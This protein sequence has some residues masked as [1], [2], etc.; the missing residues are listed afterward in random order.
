[1][2]SSQDVNHPN[3]LLKGGHVLD[4]A[5]GI[6]RAADVR[7]S[8]G[9]VVEVGSDLPVTATETVLDVA[10]NYVVPG[11]IDMHAHVFSTHRRSGLSLDPHVNTFSSGVTTVVDAG[12]AGWRDF[13]DFRSEVIDGARIR[14]LAYVNIVGSGMGGDWEHDVREM[15]PALAAAMAEEHRDVVVGIKTAHYWA[16]RPFDAEHPPWAAVDAA[17]EAG[18]RCGLPVMVDFY[19]WLPE[20]PYPDL[21]LDKLRPGDIHTHVFAQQFPV[22]DEQ[23]KVF[24]HLFQGR[25][26]GVIF[27]LGH[28]AASF[29]FRN[30]A[31]AIEQGFVPDSI[32]TDLH[33]GNLNGP[34]ID[35]ATT[36]SKVLA[37]GVP[38]AE[39][40]ARSTIAPAREIG[41][42]ELGTLTPG[43]EADVAVL[44]LD[45]GDF[46]FVD[47]GRTRLDSSQ[48]LRCVL[49]I[50][51]GEIVYNPLGIGVPSW[52]AAV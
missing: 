41:R 32:S 52:Q 33:T 35:M 24:D 3:L 12:T 10:G 11:I 31:P 38:L 50:R 51:A 23:G 47:C 34:V 30:A 1:M 18:E 4:P 44:A 40:I 7:V 19:P 27:D 13:A 28:G 42:P 37:M 21:I 8:D 25:E 22:I 6:D 14:V 48:R 5:N 46:G 20:R 9:R 15:R 45:E 49:T 43:T 26:R 17:V 29:W 39:V 2:S 36:M 16:T